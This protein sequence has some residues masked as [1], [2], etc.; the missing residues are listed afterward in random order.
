MTDIR[1]FCG[2]LMLVLVIGEFVFFANSWLRY[3]PPT[4]AL[5]FAF[6]GAWFRDKFP[7]GGAGFALDKPTIGKL[8]LWTSVLTCLACT[9][10]LLLHT[11][12]ERNHRVGW[13]CA[14]ASAA[15]LIA[16]V[17]VEFLVPTFFLVQYVFSMGVTIRRFLG[18]C[19][20][21]GFWFSL[22]SIIFWIRKT[23]PSLIDWK[24]NPL[25]LALACSIVIP[26]YY[27]I[28]ILQPYECRHWG[29]VNTMFLLAWLMLVA[30]IL[31]VMWL[32]SRV[33]TNV[34]EPAVA[35]NRKSRN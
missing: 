16:F 30:P 21:C 34:T 32:N 28:L 31:C 19:L 14:K 27:L 3:C 7:Y 17:L 13:R 10:I 1:K 9:I 18:L 22:P 35:T 29:T 2:W 5:Q 6:S 15:F 4:E 26:T 23:G 33:K 24:R 20:C 25:V 11:V 12:V 8:F